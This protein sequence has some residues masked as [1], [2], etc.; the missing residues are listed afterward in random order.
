VPVSAC[1]EVAL[2]YVADWLT[3]AL[4]IAIVVAMVALSLFAVQ[5]IL[6]T[7]IPV[8]KCWHSKAPFGEQGKRTLQPMLDF[9]FSFSRQLSRAK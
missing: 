8:M 2:L 9:T 3:T 1:K 5:C 4:I 7:V 6:P